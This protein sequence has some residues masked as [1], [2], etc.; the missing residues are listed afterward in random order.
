MK[1][2]SL[3]FC[4]LLTLFVNAQLEGVDKNANE[5]YFEDQF[6]L[7]ITYNFV[8]NKPVDF[9][10]R[11]LSYGLQGGFIKDVPLNR[12][13]TKAIGIGVGLALN[14]YYSN[15]VVRENAPGFT[16]LFDN[17]IPDFRR[18]K[19]ETHLVEFPLEFRWRTSTAQEYRFWRIYAGIKAAY[20]IGA[21]SK[22]VT[23]TFKDGFFNTQIEGFQY[24]LTFN[25]GYNTFNI[26][27]YYALSD[28]FK[29]EAVVNGGPIGFR[30]LRIGLI[31]YI[32]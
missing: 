25:F 21:R 31:F 26:H 7:G 32:L 30:P 1:R 12:A 3:L 10:Q 14:A 19:L 2:F 5:R 15:L 18:S 23:D 24:G 29:D 11:S 27:A 28:L 20:V 22:L 16:Y 17:S 4:L 8:R 9:T 13:G 6:Y